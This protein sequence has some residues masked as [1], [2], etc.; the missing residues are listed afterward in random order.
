MGKINKYLF[1]INKD[2]YI[3]NRKDK[4]NFFSII[5]DKLELLIKDIAY[6]NQ[7]G[8]EVSE[9]FLSIEKMLPILNFL[10]IEMYPTEEW[11]DALARIRGKELSEE[12]KKRYAEIKS[13]RT[14]ILD[15]Y[16]KEIFNIDYT[17][18]LK[19]FKTDYTSFTK[20]FKKEYKADKKII[21]GLSL[22]IQKKIDDSTVVN[23]LIQLK[24]L[25]DNMMW[26]TDNEKEIKKFI[27]K[28]Y[29]GDHT[30]WNQVTNAISNFELLKNKLGIIPDKVQKNM[31][32][33]QIDTTM[34]I[35]MKVRFDEVLSEQ[36]E[37]P[38]FEILDK[39][40]GSLSDM[41]EILTMLI[42]ET[43]KIDNIINQ[44]NS[45]SN[46]HHKYDAISKFVDKLISVQRLN[47]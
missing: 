18:M 13:I 11:F 37:E 35:Q 26:I 5:N 42:S 3:D 32:S 45:Y 1:D 44:I 16:D 27:G 25:E 29:I 6:L 47:L 19:R 10:S 20:I 28:Q 41:K 2:E 24:Q 33:Y 22:I 38:I 43:E 15:K 17:N 31:L 8:F 40:K 36:E 34:I 39:N 21:Q 4:I 14:T 12:F 23:L 30:N 9:D 7:I 46:K